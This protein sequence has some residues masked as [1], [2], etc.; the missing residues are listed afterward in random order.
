MEGAEEL[1][2]QLIAL[3]VLL[4]RG[5]GFS[6]SQ[7]AWTQHD[8]NLTTH[9]VAAFYLLKESGFRSITSSDRNRG[10]A[11]DR[12]LVDFMSSCFS[13]FSEQ[14]SLIQLPPKSPTPE[15]FT[16]EEADDFLVFH[17]IIL[18]SN[19]IVYNVLRIIQR[20]V[21]ATFFI[22]L[23]GGNVLTHQPSLT[24]EIEEDV[25]RRL[26]A[27]YAGL[28]SQSGGLKLPFKGENS[29]TLNGHYDKT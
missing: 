4:R 20:D 19:Q 3:F 8:I 16:L 15:S 11:D 6:N 10:D 17:T 13:I 5:G 18:P 14:S 23:N 21:T 28:L 1:R 22:L 26:R 29:F 7:R 12:L 2:R 24:P 9:L 27:H 25:A